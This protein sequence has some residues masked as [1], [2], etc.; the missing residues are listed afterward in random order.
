MKKVIRTD[1]MGKRL[2][3]LLKG[4]KSDKIT[5]FISDMWKN[6]SVMENPN[7]ITAQNLI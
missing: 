7:R 5:S 1:F 6:L 3:N 2:F 4:E